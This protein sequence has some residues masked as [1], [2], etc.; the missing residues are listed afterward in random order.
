M[1]F[2]MDIFKEKPV[3]PVRINKVKRNGAQNLCKASIATIEDL[4]S[5]LHG[6]RSCSLVRS[7]PVSKH[8]ANV[9]KPA[10]GEGLEKGLSQVLS[11]GDDYFSKLTFNDSQKSLEDEIFE[12]LEKVA[13][14]EIK[15]NAAI[16]NFDRI[17]FEHNENKRARVSE[18]PCED[19]KSSSIPKPLQ[20]SKTCSI[21]E[22]Q[23]VL[24]KQIEKKKTHSTIVEKTFDKNSTHMASAKYQQI[25]KSLWNLQDFDS[26]AK[27]APKKLSAA[28]VYSS[29]R[30]K[31]IWDIA[32]S[33]Q[34]SVSKIPIKSAKLS[35]SMMQLNGS[36][37]VNSHHNRSWQLHKMPTRTSA[38]SLTS[39]PPKM[40]SSRRSSIGTLRKEESPTPKAFSKY[41]ET[42][43]SLQRR[44]INNVSSI[45]VVPSQTA[46]SMKSAKSEMS[47]HGKIQMPLSLQKV[48]NVDL[49][50]AVDSSPD[51]CLV[52]GQQLL[53]KTEKLNNLSV[54]KR[55]YL[56]KHQKPA[57][58]KVSAVSMNTK[59]SSVK[60]TNE[61]GLNASHSHANLDKEAK[62]F[63]D[64]EI[65]NILSHA[66]QSSIIETTV[67]TYVTE[68]LFP[69][70]SRDAP[71]PCEAIVPVVLKSDQNDKKTSNFNKD[72]NS[73]CSDDSGHISNESDE[74]TMKLKPKKISDDLLKIF[75]EKP[76]TK[77]N[78]P[79]LPKVSEPNVAKATLEIQPTYNKSCKS[80]VKFFVDQY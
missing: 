54:K 57:S 6:K 36:D 63:K 32:S 15:L 70:S 26:F 75:E 80:E 33:R 52:K 42:K 72:Y 48:E 73:D 18:T 45:S 64:S 3:P 69:L 60:K 38:L 50:S 65:K 35:S 66:E 9:K 74:L 25:T 30:S 55:D 1:K 27:S 21:I 41:T 23:C 11:D 39:L 53:R 4:P 67:T 22:S 46:K 61:I 8:F 68:I 79:S 37:A 5:Q 43:T 14:D 34:S 51:K 28:E 17:L 76:A 44:N 13:H 12:E 24:K 62:S 7:T 59:S 40:S 16:K 19:K 49:K 47:I 71:E 10:C 2:I 56:A 78:L 20:K 29:S 58:A 77:I 31:S